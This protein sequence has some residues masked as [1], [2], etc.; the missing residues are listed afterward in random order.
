MMMS[1]SQE[2]KNISFT[3]SAK[4]K[5]IPEIQVDNLS[6]EIQSKK[7]IVINE[8]PANNV[9]ARRLPDTPF[10]QRLA[11]GGINI[12]GDITFIGNNILNRDFTNLVTYTRSATQQTL[13]D[14]CG[15]TY[16]DYIYTPTTDRLTADIAHPN[17]TEE[18]YYFA[19]F[20]FFGCRESYRRIRDD[21]VNFNNGDFDM[22]YIDVDDLEGITGNADTFSSSKSTLTLPACSRVEYAGLYWAGIYPY[23]NWSTEGA[24]EGDYRDIK[25]KLPGQNYQDITSDEVIYDS[26]ITQ[27]RPYVC[28]KD[29]TTM[30]QSLANPNGDY[31]AGNIRATVGNDFNYGLGG[32]AG[33]VMVIIYADETESSKNISIF[34]GF[35]TIDGTNNTDVLFDGFTTIP[36]GPVRAQFLTAALEGDG[37]ITGDNFQIQNTSSVFVDVTNTRNPLDNFFNGSI[38]K[39]DAFDTNRNLD[40]ENTLGFDVDL[41]ELNNPSN[42]VIAN[43]QTSF[44][45]RFTTSGDVYWPFLNVMAIEIIQPDIQLVKTVTDASGTPLPHNDPVNLNDELIYN[46]NLQNIGTD[47]AIN[48]VITDQ[49]PKNIQNFDPSTDLTLPTG[50]SLVNYETPSALNGFQG[51]LTLSVDDS[52]V[53]EGGS[54]HNIEIRVRIVSDCS[55]LTDVCSNVIEN[56]ASASY[57]GREGGVV[58]S[59]SLSFSGV[60]ACGFGEARSTN[61]LAD[62][63]TC[64]T[65]A[66][67]VTLC[68]ASVTLPGGDGFLSYEWRDGSG[69]IVSTNQDYV[70]TAVG[71]YT[72]TRVN[73]PGVP[74][75]CVAFDLTYNVGPFGSGTNPL[76]AIADRTVTCVSDATLE[77]SEIYLCG[78]SDSRTIATGVGA[79]TTVTWQELSVPTS[80]APDATCPDING[81]WVDV[82]TDPNNPTR[83]FSDAGQY[84]LIIEESGGCFDRYYFNVFKGTINPTIVPQDIICGNAGSI[85]INNVPAGYEYALVNA[86]ASAPA[87]SAYQTSNVFS[88]TTAGSYDV[89]IRNTSISCVFPFFNIAVGSVDLDVTVNTTPILCDGDSG[90]INVQVASGLPATTQYIY[91][92]VNPGGGSAGS[93]GPTTDRARTFTVN[94]SGIYTV[95]VTTTDSASTVT[96]SFSEDTPEFTVPAPLNLTAVNTKDINCSNGII[97]LTGSGGT[98]SDPDAIWLEAECGTVG[99]RWDSINDTAA[100]G[101]TYVTIRPGSNRLGSAPTNANGQITFNVD[102]ANAGTFSLWGRVIAPTTS[103]DSFW[104]TVDGGTPLNWNGIGPTSTWDWFQAN[105]YTLSAGTHTITIGFREDGALLDKLYLTSLGDTPSG[106]GGAS[107]N[108]AGSGPSVLTYALWSYTPATTAT[109][110]AISYTDVSG[111]PATFNATTLEGFTTNTTYSIPVGQEGTYEFIIIDSNNCTQIS[112]PVTISLEDQL[113]FS[114][115]HTDITCPG[116]ND[117]SITIN[118]DTPPGLIG[119]SLEYSIDGGTSFQTSNDFT[120]LGVG[121]YTIT[122]RATK[123]TSICTYTVGPISI[124]ATSAPTSTASL[125]RDSTCPQPNGTIT[126]TNATGGSGTGY[127]YSVDNGVT[128]Q[129]STI[130]NN[131][132]PGTYNLQVRDSNGC[133]NPV[134]PAIVVEAHPVIPDFTNTIDFVIFCG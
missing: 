49:L 132:T 98:A 116:N 80:P 45:A 124:D 5:R 8:V 13:T 66:Q 17:N 38:T 15:F 104:V 16:T 48:T 115:V 58:V 76:V 113:Q 82:A 78:D 19:G 62:I 1:F 87:A 30:V 7:G 79:P 69:N 83:N 77:L 130:F 118:T 109:A 40:S 3:P 68:G 22:Q 122:V 50:I 85:T 24:R 107:S 43:G 33:W 125:T 42:T 44:T 55:L 41:F 111:I 4:A 91:N 6:K 11:T 105:T 34:D 117:G 134:L 133:S 57:E 35:S 127:Q 97:S 36:A 86:G 123:G 70:A 23:N 74:A 114:E 60:D 29:V 89:Y 71:T 67:S 103:D 99:G 119:Y 92:I 18:L 28:Y 2:E 56:R 21:I 84:R 59:N 31:F 90:E 106:M 46:I 126:F 9:M 73:P 120:G 101:G 25:F 102:I 63:A 39:Y 20:T 88:V 27:Q 54:D 12:K 72:V 81:T 51:I 121:S 37:F 100:S 52:L 93:F 108:C 14:F 75:G 94:S 129:F 10:T 96:C 131:I 112:S 110:S 64:A 26:G 53:E 32:S 61:V 95:E 65:N 47:D 128:W